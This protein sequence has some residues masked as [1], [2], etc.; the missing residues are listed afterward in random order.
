M[1][2]TCGT[3]DLSV[4]TKVAVVLFFV[5]QA[6]R[7][8]GASAAVAAAVESYYQVMDGVETVEEPLQC[9]CPVGAS[10]SQH[11]TKTDQTDEGRGGCACRRS[12][13][14]GAADPAIASARVRDS[15]RFIR[16]LS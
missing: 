6:A 14:G 15:T 7:G 12:P 3:S 1:G 2:R 10:T 9:D 11:A 16:P 5:D 13:I 8:V 4:E